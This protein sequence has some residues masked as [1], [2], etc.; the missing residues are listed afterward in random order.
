MINA[1]ILVQKTGIM[2]RDCDLVLANVP[3]LRVGVRGNVSAAKVMYSVSKTEL[4][5]GLSVHFFSPFLNYIRNA[6]LMRRINAK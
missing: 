6:E 2:S 5:D 3:V 4:M 1:A